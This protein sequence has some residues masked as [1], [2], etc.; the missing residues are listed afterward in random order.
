MCKG[1][2]RRHQL[3]RFIAGKT[4]H[5]SLVAGA[6]FRSTLS[7]SGSLVDPLFDIARL[8]AHFTNN[9]AGIGVKNTIAVDISDIAD[10][11]AHVLF[12][13]KLRIAGYLPGDDDEVAFGERFASHAAQRI[14]LKTGVENV[15]ADGVANFIGMTFGDGFRR[16]NVTARHGLKNVKAL[17]D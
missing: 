6:L 8:L 12:K 3:R 7:F 15:I 9:P 13:V 2:R 1:N 4:E 14:L 10:G 5:Q 16:K 17:K 11:S